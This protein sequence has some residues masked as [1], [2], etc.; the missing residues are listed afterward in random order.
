M[1]LI[2]GPA[3]SGTTLLTFLLN[4]GSVVCLDEPDFHNP[5]QSHRGIPVLKELFLEK[6]FPKCPTEVMTYGQAIDLIQQI[7]TVDV[8]GVCFDCH[9]IGS[10]WIAPTG[11]ADA[12]HEKLASVEEFGKLRMRVGIHA[13]ATS[14]VRAMLLVL[15]QI[16]REQWRQFCA[17]LDV[18]ASE[19]LD[20]LP[21]LVA[22][23]LRAG[24]GEDDLL[25]QRQPF[26]GPE[27]LVHLPDIL[28]I[29]DADYALGLG[30]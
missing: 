1:F 20:V 13:H 17:G 21:R 24:A 11:V 25:L 7:R 26:I 12:I 15:R 8:N 2:G 3:F 27:L 23:L 18:G 30:R 6:T 5:Q 10:S 16:H 4:Q 14:R 29:D 22:R 19:R 9:F 28:G